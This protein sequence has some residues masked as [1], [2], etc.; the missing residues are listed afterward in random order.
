MTGDLGSVDHAD[1]SG[2]VR[3]GGGR[4]RRLR[5]GRG[6]GVRPRPFVSVPS[7]EPSL[8]LDVVSL[9]AE[10]VEVLEA[11]SEEPSVELEVDCSPVPDFVV[12]RSSSRRCRTPC[13]HRLRRAVVPEEHVGEHSRQH[14]PCADARQP[15]QAAR[16]GKASCAP[17]PTARPDARPP[18]A[19]GLSNTSLA[20]ESYVSLSLAIITLPYRSSSLPAMVSQVRDGTSV[21][22]RICTASTHSL[23]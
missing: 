21:M 11:V 23:Q 16:S 8:L 20:Y 6:G 2:L 17:L 18:T 19:G 22:H 9:W 1:G 10:S 14:T 4:R 15:P 7:V 5:V 13:R 3:L 12:R